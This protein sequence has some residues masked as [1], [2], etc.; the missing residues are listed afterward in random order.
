MTF[1][2]GM[3]PTVHYADPDGRVNRDESGLANLQEGIM[4][5]TGDI[6]QPESNLSKEIP[7]LGTA[8]EIPGPNDGRRRSSRLRGK[9]SLGTTG[10]GDGIP[11]VSRQ[12]SG[13]GKR[14]R[15]KKTPVLE[16]AQSIGDSVEELKNEVIIESVSLEL[17]TKSA[18]L[19]ASP[20]GDGL[21]ARTVSICGEPTLP[22]DNGKENASEVVKLEGIDVSDDSPCDDIEV[23]GTVRPLLDSRG[24][25]CDSNIFENLQSI[26]ILHPEEN[27]IH[28]DV[29]S[30][31]KK[32]T[33][34]KIETQ[35]DDLLEANLTKEGIRVERT[36]LISVSIEGTGPEKSADEELVTLS[37][38]QASCKIT[39]QACKT[40]TG[41][42]TEPVEIDLKE[43]GASRGSYS[44]SKVGEDGPKLNVEDGEDGSKLNGNDGEDSSSVTSRDDVEHTTATCEDKDF[45]ATSGDNA[46]GGKLERGY[47]VF[48]LLF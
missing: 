19:E 10:S 41:H 35:V 40:L 24:D 3:A 39:L 6:Q 16:S 44:T 22:H 48:C 25:F 5:E 18:D 14:G 1:Y 17:A 12:S 21:L 4:P 27:A 31:S 43:E 36:R 8:S 45:K 29:P 30:T 20:D 42:E 32:E 23:T 47:P 15:R 9:G 7:D 28:N 33:E 26:V 2:T 46:G 37:I 34:E 38:V 13:S 11:P